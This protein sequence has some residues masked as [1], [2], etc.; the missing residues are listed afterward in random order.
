MDVNLPDGFS[1]LVRSY[2]PERENLVPES[3]G[4]ARPTV[5][6]I[7]NR[8]TWTPRYRTR[9]ESGVPIMD[10]DKAD[11]VGNSFKGFGT[12]IEDALSLAL[13]SLRYYLATEEDR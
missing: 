3:Y 6:A 2:D 4:G 5:I 1:W 13:G 9:V 10:W 8:E 7:I 12:S 11:E